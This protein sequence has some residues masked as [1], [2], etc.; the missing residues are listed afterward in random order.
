[1][2]LLHSKFAD[3]AD[4]V[5]VDLYQNPEHLQRELESAVIST[6]VRQWRLPSDEWTFI[7]DSTGVIIARFQG[8][9]TFDEIQTELLKLL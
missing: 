1:M 3:K 2:S 8:F 6:A 4:F 7:I 5:H 9:A